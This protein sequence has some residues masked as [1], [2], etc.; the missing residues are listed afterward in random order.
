MLSLVVTNFVYFYCFYGL[1]LNIQADDQTLH[2]DL[3]FAMI[4]GGWESQSI[5]SSS[6]C[7]EK[8]NLNFFVIYPIFILFF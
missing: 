6:H 4:A 5:F 2:H 7:N 8:I 3:M 1:K